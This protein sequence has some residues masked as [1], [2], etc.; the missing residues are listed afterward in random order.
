MSWDLTQ[1]QIHKFLEEKKRA[2][3]FQKETGQNYIVLKI[4]RHDVHV[5]F[6]ILAEGALLQ[7]LAYFPF[8][9]QDHMLFDLTRFF[10]II[11]KEVD[12]PGFGMDEQEKL[13]FYRLVIPCLDKKFDPKLL[14]SYLH[15]TENAMEMFFGSIG[16]IASGSAKLDD[17]LEE[18]KK[19]LNRSHLQK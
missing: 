5:F 4:N 11:N 9:Y 2:P 13:L 7:I 16:I 15:A 3:I 18:G 12:M 10:H 6:V 14:E 8:T 17:L 1:E 19:N